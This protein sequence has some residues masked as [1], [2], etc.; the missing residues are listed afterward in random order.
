[1]SPSAG[2]VYVYGVVRG[3]VVPP[4][5]AEGVGGA[6]VEVVEHAGLAALVSRLKTRDLRVKRK[7]LQRHLQV[8]EEAFAATTI[9]PCP[10]GTV[11]KSTED[12]ADELLDARHDDLVAALDRLEGSVQMNVKAVYDEEALLRNIVQRDPEI[13][14]LRESTRE[15]GDAG[16]YERLRL[17]EIVA[18]AISEQRERD[19]DRL[20]TT[21]AT[22]AIDV[23]LEAPD[24]ASALKASFLVEKNELRRFDERLD[25]IARSE[26]PLLRFEVI[27][28]L[29]PT[30]F[31]AAYAD[32]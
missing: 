30:A 18:A 21:L 15:L 2:G 32:A 13:A 22:P 16:Y 14:Q 28:P 17:G 12:V 20:V 9:L 1:M 7:D 4:V 6:P 25:A 3:G 24:D 23:V 26:Q 27:G 31:A 8:L 11:V 19:S 5:N 29:P 10:F